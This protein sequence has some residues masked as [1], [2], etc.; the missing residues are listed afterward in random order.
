M[1]WL[2][3]SFLIFILNLN[4]VLLYGVL[5]NESTN[6]VS[7]DIIKALF[8]SSISPLI[9]MALNYFIIKKSFSNLYRSFKQFILDGKTDY[10][11]SLEQ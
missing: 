1:A 4:D 9:L 11:E 5:N 8:Y 3:V 7:T 6:A 2:I 10:L